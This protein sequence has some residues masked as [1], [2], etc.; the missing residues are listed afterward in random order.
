NGLLPD[1]DLLARLA[2]LRRQLD[3]SRFLEVPLLALAEAHNGLGPELLALVL[4]QLQIDPEAAVFQFH[5]RHFDRPPSPPPRRISNVN[6]PVGGPREDALP[7]EI[8][9][10]CPV[11]RA[12]TRRALCDEL[13]DFGEI[14]PG[15]GVE[16][17]KFNSPLPR[18]HLVAVLVADRRREVGEPV[19]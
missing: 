5:P 2:L 14:G 13:V 8:F 10:L 15:E 18:E 3:Q 9:G 11:A 6:V 17:P 1:V 7:T 12:V 16:L 19:L 4:Q